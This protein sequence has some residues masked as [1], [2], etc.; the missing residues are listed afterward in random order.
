MATFLAFQDAYEKGL[1]RDKTSPDQ[2]WQ[3]KSILYKQSPALTSIGRF[4]FGRQCPILFNPHPPI[5]TDLSLSV[6]TSRTSNHHSSRAYLSTLS[7]T[8]QRCQRMG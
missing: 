1:S 5:V 6:I 2:E 8:L 3:K 7:L 4:S